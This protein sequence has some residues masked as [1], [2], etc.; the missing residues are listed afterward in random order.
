[1]PRLYIPSWVSYHCEIILLKLLMDSNDKRMP[2]M[3]DSPA[4]CL[5]K[6][7]HNTFHIFT[8]FASC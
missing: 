5:L 4:C 8:A 6:D 2:T 7:D 1:M 3:S